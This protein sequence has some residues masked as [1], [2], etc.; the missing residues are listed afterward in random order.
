MSEPR[1]KVGDL[2]VVKA[3]QRA[4]ALA[5]REFDVRQIVGHIIQMEESTCS[6][7]MQRQYTVRLST[8]TGV[9]NDLSFLH[10][11]ELDPAPEPGKKD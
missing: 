4:I 11:H 6:G 8:L 3:Q 2:V 5:G 7:G 9:N 1:F 10:E